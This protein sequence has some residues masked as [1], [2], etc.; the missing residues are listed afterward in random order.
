[1]AK[2]MTPKEIVKLQSGDKIKVSADYNTGG[3][4][5]LNNNLKNTVVII[6]HVDAH[7]NIFIKDAKR[8]VGKNRWFF[9]EYEYRFLTLIKY[10]WR[11]L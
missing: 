7:G 3:R 2:I 9:F 4:E 8:L 6:D 5:D 11:K 10:R 1:M